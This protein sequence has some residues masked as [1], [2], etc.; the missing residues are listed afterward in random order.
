MIPTTNDW[1][2][3]LEVTAG[4]EN[5]GDRKTDKPQDMSL[6]YLID[7]LN[8]GYDRVTWV[9][10]DRDKQ[11]N[12][13]CQRYDSNNTT[14]SLE[15]F[16]NV[17]AGYLKGIKVT[18]AMSKEDY[19]EADWNKLVSS[20]GSS[21]KY[22]QQHGFTDLP[23]EIIDSIASDD[24]TAYRFVSRFLKVNQTDTI[25]QPIVDTTLSDA[26]SIA[27]LYDIYRDNPNLPVEYKEMSIGIDDETEDGRKYRSH[28]FNNQEGTKFT[29]D[30]S[31][32]PYEA[33]IF[34]HSHVG[35]QCFLAVW[36]SKD[37]SDVVFVDANGRF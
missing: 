36:K 19:D 16:I 24:L 26:D 27:Y 11:A 31:K 3:S 5:S 22:A 2:N 37:P 13:I 4:N 28:F 29:R 32:I 18:A 15:A 23:K 6:D 10:S 35:C 1:L 8:E 25:P 9:G 14:W 17:N 12:E 20:P 21:L 34:A 33:P 7:L 30:N